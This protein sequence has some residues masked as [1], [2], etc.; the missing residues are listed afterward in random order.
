MFLDP[1]PNVYVGAI[2]AGEKVVNSTLSDTWEMLKANYED[3]LAI[4]MEGY[5]F[6]Q[7]AE[8]NQQIEAL[9]IRGISDLIDDKNKT[10]TANFQR[11]A[12]L[13]ASAFAF[14]VL[15]E[16]A[17][18]PA[19]HTPKT[20]P[21]IANSEKQ[22]IDTNVR[23]DIQ[24]Q[25]YIQDN[26]GSLQVGNNTT[27]NFFTNTDVKDEKSEGKAFLNRGINSLLHG[28]YTKAK[29]YL[30]KADFLLHEDQLPAESAQVKYLL[31][32]MLLEGNRPFSATLQTMRLVEQFLETAIHLDPC[33]SYLYALSLFKS[34]F[35][36]NGYPRLDRE[37]KALM[38]Q[39][40]LMSSTPKDEEN[41]HLL[42]HCQPRLFNDRN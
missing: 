24:D 6:L 39:A 31:A 34:D 37:A 33:Y 4:E 23:P 40:K 38:Q 18:D 16:L 10:D 29:R 1:T 27:H 42:H 25:F 2:A 15:A 32:L 8:A 7:A 36:H 21:K 30:E 3:T 35:A 17:E 26:H 19:F 28:N 41:I 11:I 5:G 20:N 9:I 12:A 22:T 14:E 13:H